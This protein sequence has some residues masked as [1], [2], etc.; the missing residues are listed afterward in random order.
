M[1][2][3]WWPWLVL[4]GLGFYH[5][6][7]PA[8]GWLFAVALG[9]HRQSRLTVLMSLFPIAAGHALA[10]GAAV[11]LVIGA[12]LVIDHALV[13]IAT[14]G[15]LIIW[16]MYHLFYGTRHR[17]RVGMQTGYAGLLAWSFLMAIGH[18]AGLMLLPVLIPLCL[19]TMPLPPSAGPSAP[20]LLAFAAVGVHTLTMLLVIGIVSVLVYDWLGVGFLRTAWINLDLL[21]C[22]ALCGTGILLLVI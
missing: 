13:K 5:G 10:V 15:L 16:A 4:I 7:N 22:I 19:P 3:T 18:G 14:G 9:L 20:L 6:L 17:L 2:Q 12:G 11:T 1:Q 8:M 21:W